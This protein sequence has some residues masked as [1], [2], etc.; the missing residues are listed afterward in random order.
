MNAT[1]NQIPETTH[2]RFTV[3]LADDEPQNLKDLVDILFQE[4]YEILLASNG[5]SAIELA[6]KHHPEAIV[7][8][9]DMPEKNGLEAIKILRAAPDTML[10]PI[11]MATGKMLTT[12]D[13]RQALE[14]GANDYIRKPF[15]NVEIIARLNA[16][17]HLHQQYQTRM[18]LQT[19]MAQK[20]IEL[21]NQQLQVNTQA[22]AA[23]K[24]RLVN[25]AENHHHFIEGL[26]ELLPLTN[27]NGE[28]KIAKLISEIKTRT[29]TINWT[30]F[31]Y[32]FAQIH[33][34]FYTILNQRFPDIS[35][36]DRKLCGLM[37]LNLSTKE[38]ASVLNVS[39]ET[40]KK[41]KFRLKKKFG[42]QAGDSLIRFIQEIN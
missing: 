2:Y 18:E 21:I 28:E 36:S 17:I 7:M 34:S 27:K 14:A 8:D 30:E 22:M 33:Q 3:L 1:S 42:L 11:I 10:I 15:D 13:L 5:T 24:M 38:I 26:K 40:I 31:D 6:A 37:K 4:N 25:N 12:T 29:L 9:W 16:M 39:L 20:E 19:R 32:L 41:N 23:M 35:Q